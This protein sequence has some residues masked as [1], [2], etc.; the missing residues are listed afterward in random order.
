MALLEAKTRSKT[1][2]II[3]SLTPFKLVLSNIAYMFILKLYQFLHSGTVMVVYFNAVPDIKCLKIKK[4]RH[5]QKRS[6]NS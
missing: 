1:N 3:S 2:N 6:G 5:F 4:K